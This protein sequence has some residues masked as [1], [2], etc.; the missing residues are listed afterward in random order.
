M[1]AYQKFGSGEQP[2]VDGCSTKGDHL[3]GHYYVEFEKHFQSEWQEWL[4]S[5]SGCAQFLQWQQEHE[6]LKI[7]DKIKQMN[8]KADQEVDPKKKQQLLSK[9]PD[10]YESFKKAYK[11]TYFAKT[12]P[13]GIECGKMLEEWEA[14]AEGN[15]PEESE[16][17]RL[18]QKMNAWVLDGFWATYSRLGISFDHVDYES[19][20]YSLGKSICEDAVT[21]GIF[22]R[23]ATGAVAVSYEKMPSLKLQGEKVL[24][25]SNG[26]SVYMT[27][28]L[29][30]A[31]TRW[32]RHS[33]D[34]MV[35]VV[36]DEQREHFRILFELLS[37][38]QPKMQGAFHHLSYGM[39]NL[40]TGRMK[41]R[42]GTVVDADNLLDEVQA[43]AKEA[44]K[45]KVAKALEKAKAKLALSCH[46]GVAVDQEE[47]DDALELSEDEFE[48]RG[49]CIGLAALKFYILNSPPQ[50][51]ML[52]SPADSIKFEGQTGPYILYCYARTRSILR[53]ASTDGA[54]VLQGGTTCLDALGTT[55]EEGVVLKCLFP[56]ND[57]LL[58]AAKSH[59]PA[60]V[61]H[62][63]F[64]LAQAFNKLFNQ[65]EKHPIVH[66]TIPELRNA[67]LLMTEAVGVALRK[68]MALLGIDVLERM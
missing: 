27:Q 14:A 64:D 3:V 36:A 52:Y 34:K 15:T 26:T 6:G 5:D 66:C 61:C 68:G 19:Q 23:N 4:T 10:L 29:G 51:T 56:F 32:D 60:K 40:T 48:R 53:N 37:L 20:T 43:L 12:S 59:N 31:V 1:L 28:D 58:Q 16:V 57:I 49:K 33:A 42:E 9:V 38:L 30:T 18:W 8:E 11:D 55:A 46:T 21:S 7:L 50:S 45:Q 63:L 22:H 35:Y 39:V 54:D 17:Y 41:S 67:R 24:L 13:L 65:K 44:T 2:G 62:A 47:D 25:R